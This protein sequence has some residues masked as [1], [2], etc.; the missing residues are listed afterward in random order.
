MRRK[1]D[2]GHDRQVTMIYW[3]LYDDDSFQ[4]P[5]SRTCHQRI[6]SPTSVAN[7]DP[8]PYLPFFQ[9]NLFQIFL[10]NFSW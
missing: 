1:T 3:R 5:I 7:I 4:P 9:D 6:S 2:R 8:F 10:K